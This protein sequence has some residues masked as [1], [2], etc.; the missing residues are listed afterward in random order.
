VQQNGQWTLQD[1]AAASGGR[2]LYSSGNLSDT[3]SLTFQG[4]SLDIVYVQHPSLGTFAVDIDGSTV[5]TVATT[6]TKSIFGTQTTIRNLT[7]GIHR[8]RIYPVNGTVAVDAFAAEAILNA[9]PTATFTPTAA[10]MVATTPAAPA[11]TAPPTL[12][13]TITSAGSTSTTTPTSIAPAVALPYVESFDSG[14]NW[15]ATGAWQIQPGYRGQGWFVNTAQRGQV[16]LLD[17][18]GPID[19]HSATNPQLTFWQKATLSSSDIIAIDLTLDGGMTWLTIDQQS[20]L[21]TDWGVRTL[22]LKPYRGQVIRLR[23]RLDTT[24]SLAPNTP[25]IGYWLDELTVQDVV[26]PTATATTPAPVAP[27][28]VPATPTA[29]PATSVPTSVPPTL[30][31]THMPPTPT[32]VPTILPTAI[33]PT[34]TPIPTVLPPTPVPPTAIPPTLTPVPT[35]VPTNTPVQ[36]PASPTDMPSMP[37][38]NP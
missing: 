16:N 28:T 20:A 36:V 5:L 24:Q 2:Y 3:L 25:S 11:N 37:T 1:A 35:A 14:A 38:A 10:P 26:A 29:I 33:P 8:L 9:N 15:Q 27:T 17:Q 22:D 6:A 21:V 18:I 23:F 7:A 12:P 34:L 31:P 32:L 13:A 19:L 30:T 4:S